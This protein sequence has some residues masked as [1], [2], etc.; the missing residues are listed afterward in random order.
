[1]LSCFSGAGFSPERQ[2]AHNPGIRLVGL[3]GHGQIY[4]D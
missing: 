2:A 3:V 4:A 1:V